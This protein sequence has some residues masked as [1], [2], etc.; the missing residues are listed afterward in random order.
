MR[1]ASSSTE[2]NSPRRSSRRSRIEKNSSTWLSQLAW[3]GVK[4]RCTRGLYSNS[5]AT[6]SVWWA[7][8][9][10]DYAVQV[11]TFGSL[12]HQVP[13]EGDEIVRAGRVGHPAGDVA[14]VHVQ[15]GEQHHGSVALVLELTPLGMPGTAGLVGLMRALAWMEVFSSTDHTMAFSGG[16]R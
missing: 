6:W 11:H 12:V 15:A 9:V 14:L 8:E 4:C 1:A 7:R 5:S 2:P 16:L 13:Q 10:V 3:V